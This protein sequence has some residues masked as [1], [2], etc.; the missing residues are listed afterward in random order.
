MANTKQNTGRP[1][2]MKFIKGATDA[3]LVHVD[4]GGVYVDAD[5]QQ[6]DLINPSDT[7]YVLVS[8]IAEHTS[9]KTVELLFRH[10]QT[11]LIL[12][13]EMVA[14]DVDTGEVY[15]GREG[16][17]FYWAPGL[18]QRIGGFFR[19]FFV[20]TPVIRRYQRTPEGKKTT[21][22]LAEPLEDEILYPATPP[23]EV[24]TAPLEE[25]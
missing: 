9:N 13:G 19:A 5:W 7:N 18:K 20:Q 11:A 1:R 14:Q 10:H 4:E 15:R 17:L 23:D 3:P 21:L 16:D 8:G 25:V 22:Y 2:S 6:V 24:G 12:S